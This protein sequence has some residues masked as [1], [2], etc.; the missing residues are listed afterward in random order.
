MKKNTLLQT[1]SQTV[2]P[3]FAY[4]LTSQQ[5]R[6]DFPNLFNGNLRKN[7]ID[8][9]EISIKGRVIDGKGNPLHD[10]MIEI[11]QADPQGN[12]STDQNS[13][14]LGFGRMGTG[15][16]NFIGFNFL[17]YKPGKINDSS[18]PHINLTVFARGML[19]HLFTRIYFSDEENEIDEVFNQVD[20]LLRPRLIAEKVNEEEYYFDII[21]QGENETIFFD[22]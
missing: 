3:F 19:N 16:D 2:G 20:P 5:Y 21:L 1:S 22:I 15:S 9:K 8:G 13:D 4:G 18:A 14:F 6:Y 10:A 12:Y 17:T 11:W 7:D